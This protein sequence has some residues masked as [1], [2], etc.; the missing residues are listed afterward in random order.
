MKTTTIIPTLP[1]WVMVRNGDRNGYYYGSGKNVKIALVEFSTPEELSAF[2]EDEE[3]RAGES[4]GE[5]VFSQLFSSHNW[6]QLQCLIKQE[7]N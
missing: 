2:I 5:Y 6:E 4:E 1:F 3:V 7:A